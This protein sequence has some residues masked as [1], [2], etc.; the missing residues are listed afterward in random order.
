MKDVL[1]IVNR[2]STHLILALLTM[3]AFV[4]G[5]KRDEISAFGSRLSAQG[6]LRGAVTPDAGH[7]DEDIEVD[8][9]GDPVTGVPV[10]PAP[11]VPKRSVAAVQPLGGVP[12]GRAET[13]PNLNQALDAIRPGAMPALPE[14]RNLYLQ[15]LQSE[16]G[17][18]PDPNLNVPP[19]PPPFDARVGGFE[20]PQRD[21]AIVRPEELDE[22][23][24]EVLEDDEELD[25]EPLDE[26]I[27]EDVDVT[28]EELLE[29]EEDA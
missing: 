8:E 1:A 23:D 11:P 9:N 26:D 3:G 25:D 27:E 18:T 14:Q 12:S 5:Y 28:D 29:E 10:T 21:P 17:M 22:E 2:L 13:P 4:C 19:A 16:Q 7:S 15:R 24:E 6:G 20:P